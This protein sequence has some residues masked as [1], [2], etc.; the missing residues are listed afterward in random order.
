MDW[1]WFLVIFLVALVAT[2]FLTPLA[3]RIAEK[4]GII[5]LPGKNRINT[6]PVPRLG[7]L[8]LVG[9]IA[10]AVVAFYLIGRVVPLEPPQSDQT[11]NINYLG[12]ALA[13][14]V[15]FLVGLADD[16]LEIKTRYKLVVEAGA[17]CI[18]CASGILFD[19]FTNPFTGTIVELG[20][21]A[22]PITIIYLLVF[23]NIINIIDGLDGLACGVVMIS[24]AAIFIISIQKGALE[25]AILTMAIIGACLAFLRYNLFPA[26]VFMG[27]CGALSLGFLL[28]VASLFGV[29]RTPAL[30]TLLVPIM[31][32][33]IPVI[34]SVMALIRRL[35]S[36]QRLGTM[37]TGHIHHRLI[38][39]GLSQRTTVLIILLLTAFLAV[40]ALLFAVYQ[41]YTIRI[42]IVV[43]LV[44][45]VPVLIGGLGLM[46]PALQHVYY[47]RPL[48]KLPKSQ[49]RISA[50]IVTYDSEREIVP[51][52][53]SMQRY[54]DLSNLDVFIVDN[55]ST[56]NTV[57]AI[58]ATA[59]W[60]TLI[61]NSYNRGFG[62]G[63]N[64]VLEALKSEYHAV[65]NPDIEFL[66]DT[67]F[68]LAQF[69][70]DN[71]GVVMTAPRVL[72]PDRT[73][74]KLPKVQPEPRY[75]IARRFEGSN[76]RA[77][78]LAAEYTRS[79]EDFIGPV[80]IEHASGSFFMIRTA[81][82][83]ELN[84]FDERF[85]LYFED[86]DLSLRAS[87]LGEIM[88]YPGTQVIHGYAR[89]SRSN[90][91]AFVAQIQSMFR[92]FGKHGW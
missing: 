83:K 28:G 48:E 70:D 80:P 69:L 45:L 14:L 92:Y 47:P 9:G 89:E 81:V 78:E 15:V 60:A 58:E 90:A 53:R 59:P 17:A 56:D 24:A 42:A 82:F 66:E 73:E 86:N 22:W 63:H 27:D 37:D 4:L 8:A 30:I 74:Q 19:H 21:A 25:A 41:N 20:L 87:E 11:V 1:Y 31:V 46:R 13:T 79:D 52:L 64:Q 65:I 77:D 35:R 50:S 43:V 33:G 54:L 3:I 39:R 36:R 49:K 62:A 26:R 55:A 23:A 91:R 67:I 71:P 51:L 75:L 29:V 16:F 57:K 88:F 76:R 6:S 32:A 38:E 34:D 85:F 84:G 40:C 68:E 12:V 72:N 5:D 7:G 2:F 10:I 61:V 18:A 44:V